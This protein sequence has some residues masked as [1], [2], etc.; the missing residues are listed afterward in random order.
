MTGAPLAFGPSPG[1]GSFSH[2]KLT[3]A[4][5]PAGPDLLSGKDSDGHGSSPVAPDA[6][7]DIA[8]GQVRRVET[9]EK[10]GH[11]FLRHQEGQ[12]DANLRATR[13]AWPRTVEFLRTAMPV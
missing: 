1:P 4:R 13:K 6:G 2:E 5:R 12:E 3:L 8:P 7:G 10:A 9:C 11:A